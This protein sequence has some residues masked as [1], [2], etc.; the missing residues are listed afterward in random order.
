MAIAI[1]SEFTYASEDDFVQRFLI[2][3]LYRL[4]FSIVAN[5]HRS[6]GELGKDLVFAE[7]DRFGH[8]RYC[9][10]QAK[11]EQS[12]GLSAVETVIQDCRQAFASPFTH[13]HTHTEERIQT[14]YAVNGGS[15]SE[16]ARQHFFGSVGHPLAACTRLLDGK[17]LL[18]LDRWAAANRSLATLSD[19]NGLLLETRYNRRLASL[20]AHSWRGLFNHRPGSSQVG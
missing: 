10:L 5:Y 18:A 13:P 4:G 12:I 17:S 19:L 16:D 9:G 15:I 2:P 8:I 1:A 14:F 20:M 3:L 11:Y 7:I 6:H